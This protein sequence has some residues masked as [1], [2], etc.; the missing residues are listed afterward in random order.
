MNVHKVELLIIDFDDVGKD[1]IASV[2]ENT[3]YPNHCI[4]PQ[5][6]NIQTVDI[7]EWR[8]NHPLNIQDKCDE[9]YK[10]LFK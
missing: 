1:G 10:K 5:V 9:E 8:D 6:K 7:G 3:C 4:S 2:I